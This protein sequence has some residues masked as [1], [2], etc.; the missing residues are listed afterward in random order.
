LSREFFQ[1]GTCILVF[2][3]LQ[4]IHLTSSNFSDEQAACNKAHGYLASDPDVPILSNYCKYMLRTRGNMEYRAESCST[5][6]AMEL[7]VANGAFPQLPYDYQVQCV[8]RQLGKLESEVLAYCTAIDNATCDE[9]LV[10]LINTSHLTKAPAISAI[11]N[12]LPVLCDEYVVPDALGQ[13]NPHERKRE[14]QFAHQRGNTPGAVGTDLS[15]GPTSRARPRGAPNPNKVPKRSPVPRRYNN[16][17]SRPTVPPQPHAESRPNDCR[18][19]RTR[20]VPP[21][22]APVTPTNPR[23]PPKVRNG[24]NYSRPPHQLQPISE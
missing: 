4:K 24:P 7:R 23:T 9:E 18:K 20:K 3:A 21:T 12:G 6:K 1:E 10:G 19:R 2:R 5:G 22:H 16:E 13:V 17:G 14:R 11:I 15:A 8:A